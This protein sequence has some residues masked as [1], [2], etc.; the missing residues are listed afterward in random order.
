MDI[1]AALTR[2]HEAMR[3]LFAK[4]AENSNFF[5]DLENHLRVHHTNEEKILYDVLKTKEQTRKDVIEAVEEHH[6]IELMLIELENFPREHE[7]WVIKLEVLEEYANHHFEEEESKI[8][9]EGA[10]VL[11]ETEV[12]EMA[13]RFEEVKEKQLGVL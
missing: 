6:I 5:D 7:R 12:T 2:H 10:E 3:K 9:P 1:F 13:A 4:T 11:K 8:F